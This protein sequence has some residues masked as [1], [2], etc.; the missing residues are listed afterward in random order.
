MLHLDCFDIFGS[1]DQPK[2][3]CS[4]WV[5]EEKENI[6]ETHGPAYEH[7][8]DAWARANKRLKHERM[9]LNRRKN[10]LRTLSLDSPSLNRYIIYIYT[11]GF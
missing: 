5:T 10:Q 6:C 4:L 1:E 11:Y 8:D 3:L 7:N 2:N 9:A